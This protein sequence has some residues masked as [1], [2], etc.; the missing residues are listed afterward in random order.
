MDGKPEEKPME[1]PKEKLS[2]LD[3]SVMKGIFESAM[4]QGSVMVTEQVNKESNLLILSFLQR[5]DVVAIIGEEKAVQL[6][7]LVNIKGIKKV[8]K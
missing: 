2:M 3:P 1:T 7:K 6:R 4:R 5:K 8:D